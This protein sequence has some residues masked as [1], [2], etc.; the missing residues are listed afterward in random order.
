LP[1]LH[2]YLSRLQ[3]IPTWLAENMP[4]KSGWAVLRDK[5]N[6]RNKSGEGGSYGVFSCAILV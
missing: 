6:I 1:P 5:Q 2:A 4:T 3:P